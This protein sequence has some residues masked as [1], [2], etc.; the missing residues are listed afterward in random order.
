MVITLTSKHIRNR[1]NQ[2]SLDSD[3][4]AH[5]N[6]VTAVAE[7]VQTWAHTLGADSMSDI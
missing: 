3:E 1:M 6:D 5:K 4:L 7:L 2:L